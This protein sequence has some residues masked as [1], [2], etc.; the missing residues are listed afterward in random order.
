M[1]LLVIWNRRS[2]KASMIHI[3]LFT[4]GGTIDG[5]DSDK[6][7]SRVKSDAAEWLKNQKDVRVT[8][9]SLFN[10]DSREISNEGP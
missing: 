2:F 7:T 9:K 6:G 1:R 4:T 10:K 5:A 8:E 3:T